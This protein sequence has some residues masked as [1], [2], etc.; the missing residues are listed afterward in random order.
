M[1][2]LVYSGNKC[3]F[4][5]N[6]NVKYTQNMTEH[7]CSAGPNWIRDLVE[8]QREKKQFNFHS[9]WFVCHLNSME[10]KPFRF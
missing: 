5:M 1:L 7:A 10:M 9:K 2:L 3:D 4:V 8:P 6:T